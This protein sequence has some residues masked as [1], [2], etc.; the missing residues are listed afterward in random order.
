MS[1]PLVVSSLQPTWSEPHLVFSLD[2]ERSVPYGYLAPPDRTGQEEGLAPARVTALL[3]GAVF[4][5]RFHCV[6]PVTISEN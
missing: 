5:H 2:T 3:H 6:S 4:L 1:S